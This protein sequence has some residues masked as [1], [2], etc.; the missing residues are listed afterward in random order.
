MAFT[1]FLDTAAAF[2]Q[3]VVAACRC[4]VA[5]QSISGRPQRQ[6]RHVCGI[7]GTKAKV[8][9]KNRSLILPFIW[10]GLTNLPASL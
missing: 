2:L 6:E 1:P 10:E 5:D 9:G 8:Q 4:I 7:S 3:G